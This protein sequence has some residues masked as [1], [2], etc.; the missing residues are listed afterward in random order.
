MGWKNLK[1]AFDIG[2]IVHVTPQGI[3]IGS[4]YLPQVLVIDPANGRIIKGEDPFW[5]RNEDVRRYHADLSADPARVLA[6]IQAPDTFATSLSVYTYSG[7]EIIE[8]YCEAYDF[9]NVTHDGVLMHD[10]TFSSSKDVVIG[11]AKRNAEACLEWTESEIA[12]LQAEI[13]KATT[14]QAKHRNERALL[15]MAYPS[16]VPAA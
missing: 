15:E 2:H 4:P 3:S 1:Q 5:L 14:W 16:P 7:A 8:K 6:L 13:H 12:R 9:P 10:N 11:W